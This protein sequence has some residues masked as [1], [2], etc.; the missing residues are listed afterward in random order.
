MAFGFSTSPSD[1]CNLSFAWSPL[2]KVTR[3]GKR[4]SA[5][6]MVAMLAVATGAGCAGSPSTTAAAPTGQELLRQLAILAER[7]PPKPSG[8]YDYVKTQGWYLDFRV[9]RGA[10][11]GQVDP[12]FRQQ[13]IPRA[14]SGRLEETR[15]GHT[16]VNDNLAAAGLAG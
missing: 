6:V 12:M 3:G 13:W 11:T 9:A 5:W 14:G 16:T 8:R 4:G 10:T 1:G 15:S 7:Q 2:L